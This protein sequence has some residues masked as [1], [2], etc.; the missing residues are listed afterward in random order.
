M[1]DQDV[2]GERAAAKQEL[3][4]LLV[5]ILVPPLKT[6]VS[7]LL[8]KHLPLGAQYPRAPGPTGS[9]NRQSHTFHQQALPREQSPA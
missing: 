8:R 3:T 1:I 7:A 2:K 9:S 5:D 6:E 4:Q